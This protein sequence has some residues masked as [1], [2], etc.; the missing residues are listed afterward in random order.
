MVKKF[1]KAILNGMILCVDWHG[2]HEMLGEEEGK[3][4]ECSLC[5][6]FAVFPPKPIETTSL[7]EHQ[8]QEILKG[9]KIGW[10]AEQYDWDVPYGTIAARYFAVNEPASRRNWLRVPEDTAWVK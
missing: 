4:H 6:D 7:T 8:I 9:V 5:E 3:L 10:M 1:Q 2:I